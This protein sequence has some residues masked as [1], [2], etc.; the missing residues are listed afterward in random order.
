MTKNC[1]KTTFRL[2]RMFTFKSR[3]IQFHLLIMLS[4]N[5]Y[6]FLITPF[7]LYIINKPVHLNVATGRP[8]LAMKQVFFN[9]KKE[10]TMFNIF[11]SSPST[12]LTCLGRDNIFEFIVIIKVDAIFDNVITSRHIIS[13]GRH[14]YLMCQ[15]H[16]GL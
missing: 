9:K 6:D 16:V 5:N 8:G 2:S 7:T 12:H 10:M 15:S 1:S 14:C 11:I 3:C 13:N 4:Y